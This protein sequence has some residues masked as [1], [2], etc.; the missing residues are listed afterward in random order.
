LKDVKRNNILLKSN[1]GDN[2]TPNQS[3]LHY[4][5]RTTSDSK[6]SFNKPQT[7]NTRINF[8]PLAKI[9]LIP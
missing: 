6:D 1:D 7:P 2:D 9:I 4:G 3:Y 5:T 8:M